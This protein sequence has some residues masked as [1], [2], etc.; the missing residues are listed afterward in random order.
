MKDKLTKLLN[1]ADEGFKRWLAARVLEKEIGEAFDEVLH[2]D[3]GDWGEI[4]RLDINYTTVSTTVKVALK[5]VEKYFVSKKE[6]AK[7]D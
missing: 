5:I 3:I 2:E 4:E 6:Y 1:K 7:K